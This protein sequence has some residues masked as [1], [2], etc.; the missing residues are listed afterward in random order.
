[1]INGI[2]YYWK[3][4]QM[5]EFAYQCGDDA[6]AEIKK[7]DPVV[8]CFCYDAGMAHKRTSG[9]TEGMYVFKHP[10]YR[11]QLDADEL[12]ELD[13]HSYWVH[14]PMYQFPAGF[15]MALMLLGVK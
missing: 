2:L 12:S 7:T 5:H 3:D 4:D 1:M 6:S 13:P 8:D 15:R 14:I 9:W 11:K 10:E